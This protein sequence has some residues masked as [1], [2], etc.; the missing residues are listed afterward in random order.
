[1]RLISLDPR[2]APGRSGVLLVRGGPDLTAKPQLLHGD[3]ICA[4]QRP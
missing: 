2:I 3:W 1:M 4:R